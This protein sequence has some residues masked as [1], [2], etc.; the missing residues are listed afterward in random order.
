MPAVW[1]QRWVGQGGRGKERRRERMAEQGKSRGIFRP[2][3]LIEIKKSR[4]PRQ[5]V[6]RGA[7]Y[8][9]KGRLQDA[10]RGKGAFIEGGGAQIAGRRP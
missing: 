9:E 8:G 4:G 2:D 1:G 5:C 3:V 10:D 7:E 6:A